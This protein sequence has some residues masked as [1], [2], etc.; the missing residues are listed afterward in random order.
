MKVSHLLT[1]ALLT[2]ACGGDPAPD[3][4]TD[5]ASEPAAAPTATTGEASEPFSPKPD[6]AEKG[7]QIS[8]APPAPLVAPEARAKGINPHAAILADFNERVDAYM[9]VRKD[10]IK[11][12]PPLKET[13]DVAKIKAAQDGMAAQIRAARPN[14]KQ[15]DIFTPEIVAQFRRLLYPE[16]KGED[17]RDAKEILKDDAPSPAS[18]PFKVN[19]K[20]PDGAPVPTVPANLLINLPT[21]PEPLQ[22]K[23]IGKH[24]I[25]LDEDADVIVDYAVNVIR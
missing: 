13:N 9:K 14:A 16:L 15:G 22:F 12:A 24:L 6:P 20:Y 3:R 11:D 2:A 23:I 17:G 19:A 7:P 25:L 21:L 18:I 1:V 5:E 4:S 10:A 8:S